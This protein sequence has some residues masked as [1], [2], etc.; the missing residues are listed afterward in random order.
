MLG[1]STCIGVRRVVFLSSIIGM[2]AD[3]FFA[4]FDSS[5]FET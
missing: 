1:D 5:L 2:R 3:A 4:W